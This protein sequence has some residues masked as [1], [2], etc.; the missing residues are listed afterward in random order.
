[1]PD[2]PNATIDR[3]IEL[4]D[5]WRAASNVS[6]AEAHDHFRAELTSLLAPAAE[7]AELARL[8]AEFKAEE[9]KWVAAGSPPLKQ[10]ELRRARVAFH[11]A[12]AEAYPSL[13]AAAQS[14]E[15][16]KK[17]IAE[18]AEREA[19]WKGTVA[20]LN[21]EVASLEQEVSQLKDRISELQGFPYGM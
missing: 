19:E 6:P 14:A 2:E 4:A 8:H 9:A 18:S 11:W 15:T 7:W 17:Q 10:E 21:E 3:I 12:A 16:M 1:M 20:A 13:L 5:Q